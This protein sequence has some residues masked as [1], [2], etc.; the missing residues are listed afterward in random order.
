MQGTILAAKKAAAICE[1]V[2]IPVLMHAIG[3]LGVAQ[4]AH[5]HFLASTPNAILANQTM[6]DWLADDIIAGGMMPFSGGRQLV[7]EGPGLGIE[8]D[9]AKVAEYADNYRRVGKYSYFGGLES[10]RGTPLP[11][12]LR[13]A[14]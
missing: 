11:T 8:L 5:L 9:R 6:Y 4:A 3:E 13:P 14:Y 1:A 7:P 10:A 12:P 2:G